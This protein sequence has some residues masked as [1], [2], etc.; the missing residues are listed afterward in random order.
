MDKKHVRIKTFEDQPDGTIKATTESYFESLASIKEE[1]I[2]Q[3]PTSK[4]KMLTDLISCLDVV[5]KQQT[6][7]MLTIR[8]HM[9]EWGQPNRIEKQYTTKKENYKRC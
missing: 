7:D 9:D 3:I 4:E 8:I 5:H 6:R 1:I 2:K